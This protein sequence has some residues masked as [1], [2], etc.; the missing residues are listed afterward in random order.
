M[1]R[2][3]S[4]V[5]MML[6]GLVMASCT[7]AKSAPAGD[8]ASAAP[9]DGAASAAKGDAAAA[10]IG[11]PAGGTA[12]TDAEVRSRCCK[13]CAG[14]ASR[15]AAGMDISTKDCRSYAGDWNGQPG[16]DERCVAHFAGRKTVVGD[17]WKE[18]PEL[19]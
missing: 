3:R 1:Q 16:V 7:G 6:F 12:S 13:Q 14:S 17:C 8:R 19:K 10:A 9:S 15:D 18:Q 4:T 2:I 5:G 11:E